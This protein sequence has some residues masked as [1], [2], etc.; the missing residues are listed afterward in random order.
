MFP[1]A[2]AASILVPR[3][4]LEGLRLGRLERQFIRVE[5]TQ[6]REEGCDV[7]GIA[8]RVAAAFA[9]DAEDGALFEALYD[10]LA[11]LRPAASF[12][13][14][15]PSELDAIRSLRPPGPRRM[16]MDLDDD[17]LRDRIHGAWLG[18]AAGCALGK[19]VEGWPRK[20]LDAYL[21]SVGALPLDDYIPYKEGAIGAHLKT[22]TRGNIACMVRDDDLDY[23]I[24]G[25]LAL[26][27]CG[28]DLTSRNMANTWITRMPYR[29][30]YTA[31]AMAYRNFVN[32]CW[33]PESATW[34]NPYREWIGAQIR[35]D[36]FGWVSPGWPE[37]AAELAWRDARIS[38]V[39]NGIYGEMFVA[40]MLAACFATSDVEAIVEVGLSEIPARCRLAEAVRD[41]RTWCR[42]EA[43]W[44][45]VWD[46]IH[47]KYG[48]YSGVHTINNAALVVMGILFGAE[49]YGN[50]ITVAVRGGWDAD[51]NGATAGSILG[52]KFGAAA[53]PARWTG[54][55]GDRLLSSVRDCNDNRISELA[56][57]THR[58]AKAML[59][60]QPAQEPA[61]GPAPANA[62]GLPGRWRL[63]LWGELLLIVHAD[64]S[65]QMEYVAHGEVTKIR[66][67]RVDGD[68]VRFV[69]GAY[70]GDA[71]ID[72]EFDGRLAG[73]QL[74]GQCASQGHEFPATAVRVR[75]APA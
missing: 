45:A 12:A 72:M 60:A 62:D 31:E 26:E 23:P 11:A 40:A 33:P 16:A 25:L 63:E 18:R 13:Y 67:V 42:E 7:S 39:K 58:V 19:P 32:Q 22:S 50:G 74:A 5:L 54:V 3:T 68:R 51:C 10:E 24:L 43:D 52:T 71:E 56:D 34:R 35:A 57:R 9:E 65:G 48:H 66:D 59:T 53:L 2:P 46:R 37:R 21:E 30:V 4:V 49:D 75:T 73:D 28:L 55:L 6:R 69:F 41:T 70:K 1:L 47:A 20:R 14:E 29:S 27:Q 8:P 36:V 44:E 61:P 38:H 15:E 17:G 64:L